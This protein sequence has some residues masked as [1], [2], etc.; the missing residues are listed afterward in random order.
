M[1]SLVIL[2][3]DIQ[4]I[5]RGIKIFKTMRNAALLS[6]SQSKPVARAQ[7]NDL[8]IH[9][10]TAAALGK[11]RISANTNQTNCQLRL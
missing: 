1:I 2:V 10:K 6:P 3:E 9:V 11:R 7:L 4:M 8:T 5:V